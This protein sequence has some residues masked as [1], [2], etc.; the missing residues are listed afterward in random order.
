MSKIDLKKIIK[1]FE[2]RYD[3]QIP[4]PAIM[5]ILL[6][7]L[8]NVFAFKNITF[9][10]CENHCYP[11]PLAFFCW[12]FLPSG[13]IKSAIIKDCNKYL[14]SWFDE[15]IEKFNKDR[16]S[17]M[18]D[19]HAL[20]LS[21]FSDKAKEAKRKK[22]IEFEKEEKNFINFKPNLKRAYANIA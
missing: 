3:N 7:E 19:N 14:F 12:N 13:A 1:N 2:I 8:N 15:E 16:F 11:Y 17:D 22:A 20:I 9:E 10:S 18:S 6:A 5:N 4:P 21:K